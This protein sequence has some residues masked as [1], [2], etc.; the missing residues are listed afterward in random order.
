M[1]TYEYSCQCGYKLSLIQ[2]MNDQHIAICPQ[3][4]KLMQRVYTPFMFKIDNKPRWWNPKK[5]DAAED[6]KAYHYTQENPKKV[7]V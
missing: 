6:Q 7:V 3:C 5:M 1:P 2:L 4:K